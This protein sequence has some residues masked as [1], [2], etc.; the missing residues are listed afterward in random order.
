M[1][2]KKLKPVVV[3]TE[4]RGVFFGYLDESKSELPTKAMMTDVRC[5]IYWSAEVKGVL[6]LAAAAPNKDCRVGL[7]VPS[8]DLWKIT[9]VFDCTPESVTAWEMSPWK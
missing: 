9:G 8:A 3:T 1:T 4:Y 2:T 5:C 6:G 7:K